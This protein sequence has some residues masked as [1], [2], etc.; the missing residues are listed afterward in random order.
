MIRGTS[1]KIEA[2]RVYRTKLSLN[3]SDFK[4]SV[5]ASSMSDLT[6]AIVVPLA[7][8]NVALI[9]IANSVAPK[10]VTFAPNGRSDSMYSS[11][12]SITDCE[13]VL[14]SSPSTTTFT[15]PGPFHSGYTLTSPTPTTSFAH[16]SYWYALPDAA[17]LRTLS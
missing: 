14:L 1:N 13:G 3:A 4:Y 12:A 17:G 9:L 5:T 8:V 16:C 2:M 15:V 11:T 7:I 6:S 10:T